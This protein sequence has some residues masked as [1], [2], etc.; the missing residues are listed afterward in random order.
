MY[1]V[2]RFNKVSKESS[3]KEQRQF[4]SSS[5]KVMN[6]PNIKE[7]VRE[8]MRKHKEAYEILSK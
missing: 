7:L 1:K 4:T 3:D 8:D 6:L 2:K 5:G